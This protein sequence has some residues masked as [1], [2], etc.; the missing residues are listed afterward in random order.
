M[1]ACRVKMLRNASRCVAVAACILSLLPCDGLAAVAGRPASGPG[2]SYTHDVVPNVPWSIHIVKIERGHPALELLPL[3]A[4]GSRLGL[5]VVSQI[6]QAVPKEWGQPLAAINGDYF[7]SEKPYAGDPMGLQI[8]RGEL[9]SGP[10]DER[11]CLWMDA[12]G[13][14]TITNLFPRFSVTWPDGTATPVGLNE[15]RGASSAV[16][17][18]AAIGKST[19]TYT[20]VEVVLERNGQEPWLPLRLGQ[21]LKGRI[22]QLNHQGST[23]LKPDVMVLSIGPKLAS[24]LPKPAVGQVLEISTAT[25]PLVTNAWMGIGGGPVLV[26]NG[27]AVPF[28]GIQIRH[29]RSAI[30]WNQTHFFLV[31]VD[32]RQ[33][34]LSDGMTLD[35]LARYMIKLGCQHALNLD[36]GGSA[37]IW[38]MGQVMNSPSPGDER[39]AANA[40]VLIRKAGK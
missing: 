3:P 35:E 40:L 16:L 32:G 26:R 8:L 29:P 37:T 21:R 38:V 18:T 17:Y 12:N 22:R 6:V 30:G 1:S 31:E 25:K 24:K 14:P 4:H 33:P 19:R 10:S 5:A 20:G 9:I 28:E 34:G 2:F 11:A 23:E 27:K 39:P 36:G 15:M 7:Y 13:N